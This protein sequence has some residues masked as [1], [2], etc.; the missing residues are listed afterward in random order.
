M[1]RFGSKLGMSAALAGVA[2]AY[3]MLEFYEASYRG[4]SLPLSLLPVGSRVAWSIF[5]T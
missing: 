2:L 3:A 5:E 4:V 1:A